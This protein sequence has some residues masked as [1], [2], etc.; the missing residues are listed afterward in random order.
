LSFHSTELSSARQTKV[1]RTKLWVGRE[2]PR[3]KNN[4]RET[5]ASVPSVFCVPSMVV[6]LNQRRRGGYL[7]AT[8]QIPSWLP[9][10]RQLYQSE[11]CVK[12]NVYRKA[13]RSIGWRSNKLRFHERI[14]SADASLKAPDCGIRDALIS[15]YRHQ[16]QISSHRQSL[17]VT[18]SKKRSNCVDRRN[19][20]GIGTLMEVSRTVSNPD[21]SAGAT[22][23][24]LG[25]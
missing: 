3:Q 20:G 17:H 5:R 9:S 4:G 6:S 11:L 8:I 15:A 13:K 25:R 2:V 24:A 12:I 21:S 23:A 18:H 16:R 22:P 19:A 10:C 7:T 14:S 1:C